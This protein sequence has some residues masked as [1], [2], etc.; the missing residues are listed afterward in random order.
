MPT[1][2]ALAEQHIA[3]RLLD[4]AGSVLC[5]GGG[6]AGAAALLSAFLNR[7]AGLW[8]GLESATLLH[9]AIYGCAA[10]SA[11][12]FCGLGAAVSAVGTLK[13]RPRDGHIGT[14]GGLEDASALELAEMCAGGEGRGW[15]AAVRGE[16]LGA[17]QRLGGGGGARAG[18]RAAPHGG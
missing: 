15:R 1:L 12:L 16:L 18:R 17:L 10:P 5:H 13:A 3:P 6:R 4:L 11:A 9:Y 7:R 8:S 14:V 2:L